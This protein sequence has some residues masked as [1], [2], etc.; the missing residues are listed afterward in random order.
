MH[1]APELQL[2]PSLL[3]LQSIST[4]FMLLDRSNICKAHEYAIMK[5]RLRISC[6]SRCFKDVTT[7]INLEI[8]WPR[9][10]ERT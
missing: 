8:F 4:L 5:G 7:V 10:P 1:S 2:H 6:D 9:G 3:L